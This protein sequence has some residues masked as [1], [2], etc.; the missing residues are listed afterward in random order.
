MTDNPDFEAGDFERWSKEIPASDEPI[1]HGMQ[2]ELDAYTEGWRGLW[3]H[4][5]HGLY[6]RPIRTRRPYRL[7]FSM[8]ASVPT[9]VILDRI[10]LKETG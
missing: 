4:F 8:Q 1:K 10:A 2:T 5:L 7:S 9:T 3:E 6:G